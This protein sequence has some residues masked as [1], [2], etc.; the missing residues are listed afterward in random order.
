MSKFLSKFI[1]IITQYDFLLL[2]YLKKSPKYPSKLEKKKIISKIRAEVS[3]SSEY[4]IEKISVIH[5]CSAHVLQ[6]Q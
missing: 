1:I 5:V 4:W 2:K 6:Q 3:E